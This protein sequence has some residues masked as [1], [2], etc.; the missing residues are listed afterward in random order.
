M[1]TLEVLN[2]SGHLTL[3]WNPEDPEDV[4]KAREAVAALKAE[5]YTFFA[6]AG[7]TGVDEVAA[8]NGYLIV[9]RVE[10]PV[11][12]RPAPPA[13]A[14]APEG[15]PPKKRGRPPKTA[16]PPP[17]KGGHK[18]FVAVRHMGGG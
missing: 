2:R 3:K 13:A 9:D 4:A 6:V 17:A 5:G 14:A 11:E 1:H 18:E 7:R 10:D 15:P 16:S 8:G 12:Y